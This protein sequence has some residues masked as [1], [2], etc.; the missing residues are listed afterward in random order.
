[1]RKA[2]LAW[3]APAPVRWH[4][5]YDASEIAYDLFGAARN[6]GLE[7]IVSKRLDRAY[8][9][10]KCAHWIK[11]KIP[12]IRPIPG[13]GT[14]CFSDALRIYRSPVWQYRLRLLE[15]PAL[16]MHSARAFVGSGFK[17]LANRASKGLGELARNLGVE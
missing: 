2:N 15:L 16:E 6:L 1:M 12:R 7:G 9:T 17:R 10:G 8:G 13:S 4:L 3:A 11:I 14:N 5:P